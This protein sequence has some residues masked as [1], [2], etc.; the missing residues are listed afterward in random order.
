MT[1]LIQLSEPYRSIQQEARA[2]AKAIEPYAVEADNMSTVHPEMHRL[3]QE[4][5]LCK[6]VVEG[7]YGGRFAKVDPVAVCLV[8]E[9]LMGVSGNADSLFVMQGLG[10]YALTQAGTEEQ[11]RRWMPGVAA[12]RILPAVALTEPG[13]G[14]DLKSVTTRAIRA[15]GGFKLSGHKAFITNAPV[16][17]FYTVL[18]RE[19][20]GYSVFLVDGKAKGIAVTPGPELMAPHIIGEVVFDNVELPPDA[21]LGEPG[22]GFSMVLTTLAVFRVSVAAAAVGLA[23]AA[24]EE[25]VRHARKREQFGRP[26]AKLGPIASLL[27]DS[28]AEVAAARLLTYRVAEMA[29]EEALANLDHSSLAKMYATEMASRV[30]DRCVQVM[31]RWGLIKDSKVERLFLEQR[32]MRIYEGASE[33]L[34]LGISARLCKDVQ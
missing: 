20:D 9:A 14:S 4:S 23:Q 8:R 10:S 32:A 1:T 13:A 19:D 25:A 12:G 18:A 28:W 6:L 17:D 7:A 3:L 22:K 31:G 21:R 27:A 5:G 16:A 11:K 24:L 2:L 26:L 34:R 30:T 15:G 33:V 29:K